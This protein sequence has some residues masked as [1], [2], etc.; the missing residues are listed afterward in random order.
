MLDCFNFFRI[1]Q[2]ISSLLILEFSFFLDFWN[3]LDFF[4]IFKIPKFL[5][6]LQVKIFF[7]ILKKIT[8]FYRLHFISLRVIFQLKSVWIFYFFIIRIFQNFWDLGIF[9]IS[10]ILLQINYI[11]LSKIFKLFSLYSI[12]VKKINI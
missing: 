8:K 5:W 1:S 4:R 11:L 3:S 10:G 12:S 2:L 7:F 6:F 9:S